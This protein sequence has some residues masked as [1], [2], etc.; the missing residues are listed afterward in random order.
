MTR[1]KGCIWRSGNGDPCSEP[2][3]RYSNYCERHLRSRLEELF[4]RD[5]GEPTY[6]IQH[7]MGKISENKKL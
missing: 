6:R 3:V 7:L 5:N 4:N 2:T 1:V